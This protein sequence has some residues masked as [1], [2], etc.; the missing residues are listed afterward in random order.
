MRAKFAFL[1]KIIFGPYGLAILSSV[2]ESDHARRVRHRVHP[3]VMRTG[4]VVRQSSDL[5]FSG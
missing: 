1:H 3:V 4:K 5:N 2:N